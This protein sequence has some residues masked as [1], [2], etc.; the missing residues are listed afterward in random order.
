MHER[1]T[2]PLGHGN[3]PGS[4]RQRNPRRQ[5]RECYDNDS[6]RR[7]IHRACDRAFPPPA[8][9]VRRDGETAREWHERLTEQQQ[10]ELKEW[11]QQHRWSPNQLRHT[12]G[13]EIR[14]RFG[15]EAVQVTLGHASADVSQIYAER[16]LSLAA[17]VMKEVG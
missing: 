17:R 4:N 9:L 7:A 12:T 3:V 2:T 16:D 8:P 13:T 11:Q 15:L 10:V 5:A 1:R 14:K 6:Y